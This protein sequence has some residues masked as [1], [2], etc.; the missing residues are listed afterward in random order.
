MNTEPVSKE[1]EIIPNSQLREKLFE[2]FRTAQSDLLILTDI[3]FEIM[4]CE[5]ESDLE[6][7]LDLNS[8]INEMIN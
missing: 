7:L 6:I 2:I 4:N 8:D 3:L 5:S 1:I